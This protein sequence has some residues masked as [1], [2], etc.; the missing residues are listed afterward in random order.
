MAAASGR[1]PVESRKPLVSAGA[2]YYGGSTDV[3]RKNLWDL[4]RMTERAE[5]T[6]NSPHLVIVMVGLPGRGKSFL[7]RKLSKFLCW[8]GMSSEVFNVGKFRRELV[9]DANLSNSFFDPKNEEGAR[10]REEAF[11]V[12]LTEMLR[13]ISEHDNCVAILDAT[14]ASISRRRHIYDSCKRHSSSTSV[15]FIETICKDQTIL[16]SNMIDKA[17]LSPD[18]AGR[19]LEEAVADLRVRWAYFESVYETIDEKKEEDLS[20]IKLYDLSSRVLSNKVYGNI[21]K[22]TLPFLMSLHVGTRP[23][24]LLRAGDSFIDPVAMAATA[25]GAKVVKIGFD[26]SAESAAAAAGSDSS[27]T[28]A[29]DRSSSSG[30]I[31]GRNGRANSMDARQ[32]ARNAHMVSFDRGPLS[33]GME[34]DEEVPVAPNA[35]LNE[36][37][38]EFAR[39]LGDFIAMKTKLFYGDTDRRMSVVQVR[40]GSEMAR[41]P[42]TVKMLTSTLPRAL[43]TAL[44]AGFNDEDVESLPTLNPLDQGALCELSMEQI[45]AQEPAFYEMWRQSPFLTR[46]PGGESYRD[47]IARLEPL[48]VDIEQ[49]TVPVFVISHLSVLQALHSY[50]MGDADVT[51]CWQ[52]PIP[53]HTV[54]EF[55]PLLGGAFRRTVHPLMTEN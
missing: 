41:Q 19:T 23:I 2:G 22:T 9:G 38:Q 1:S 48:L 25:A 36:H 16:E 49:Q 42:R 28:G 24:F 11:S 37:G 20:F 39:L 15:V 53:I 8:K 55:T 33:C 34:D 54:I 32:H 30:S 14:N 45:M 4:E 10:Q 50:F 29:G 12:A 5:L 26:E 21:T 51:Q 18:F 52:T 35:G 13:W 44:L 6:V 31:S 7:A 40:R 47:L 27:D 43:D 17:K 46:F 3:S